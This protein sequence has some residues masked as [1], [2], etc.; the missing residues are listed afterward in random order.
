MSDSRVRR[1]PIEIC[2]ACGLPLLE[3]ALSCRSC[4][5]APSVGSDGAETAEL[6]RDLIVKYLK[7][8]RDFAAQL[9]T[10]HD[11]EQHEL[12]QLKREFDLFRA[13]AE[14]SREVED[15]FKE[16]LKA[17]ELNIKTNPLKTTSEKV[18]YGCLLALLGPWRGIV[19]ASRERRD[20]MEIAIEF[21]DKV[22]QLLFSLAGFAS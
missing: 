15:S 13:R 18:V 8:L 21:R 4:G 14:R 3:G 10:K 16:R 5:A 20:R 6:T 11:L 9:S 7:Y 2:N 22:S 19:R 1:S 17:I 12:E